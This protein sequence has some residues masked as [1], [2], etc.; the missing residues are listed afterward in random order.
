MARPNAS[1]HAQ[2]LEG[3]EISSPSGRGAKMPLPSPLIDLIDQDFSP[4]ESRLAFVE[5]TWPTLRSDEIRF[6]DLR[7]SGVPSRWRGPFYKK[8]HI[9]TVW[10]Y[11]G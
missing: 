1:S 6:Y 11:L 3:K 8:D 5:L 10:Y 7:E 9:K 2:G 4:T